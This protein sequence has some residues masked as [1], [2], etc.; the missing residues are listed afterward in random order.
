MN[1]LRLGIIGRTG[2]GDFGHSLDIGAS[3]CGDVKVVA[4]ADDNPEGLKKAQ[5]RINAVQAYSDYREMLQREKLDIVVIAPRWIDQHYEMLMAAAQAG[6]HI[7]ME[8][9]FCRTLHECDEVLRELEMRHLHLA[10]AHVSFYTPVTDRVLEAIAAGEIGEVLELRGR[11]KEDHRG[12]GEDLWVL[13]SHVLGLM[14]LIAGSE[15]VSCQANVYSAGK[16]ITKE[17]VVDGNE[18]LGLIAGDQLNAHYRFA[19]HIDGYFASKRNAGGGENRFALQIFGSKG[20][21]ELPTGYMQ[22]AGLLRDATWAPH[23]SGKK[24]ELITTGGINKPELRRDNKYEDAHVEA[25]RDLAASIREHR[26]PKCDAKMA[27]RITEM[28]VAVFASQVAGKEV[29]MPL[30]D[31]F[32]PLEK[33]R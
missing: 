30:K 22:P 17:N 21:I 27:R 33:L 26:S 29:E 15:P 11:G 25:L 6:C 23:R 3:R 12:G 8:K 20:I 13:G 19:N 5:Q 24:W 16:P 2:H 7:Y 1:T 9:P 28:I 14:A 31:R 32:N 18:G 10:I 4:I